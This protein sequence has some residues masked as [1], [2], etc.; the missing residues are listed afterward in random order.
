MIKILLFEMMLFKILL[1]KC[2]W[3]LKNFCWT[4][5][6]WFKIPLVNIPANAVYVIPTK[7]CIEMDSKRSKLAHERF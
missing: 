5:Y 6:F 1:V 3:L 4:K 2:L 7:I